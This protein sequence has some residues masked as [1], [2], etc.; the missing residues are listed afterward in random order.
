MS[1]WK[2]NLPLL[3]ENGI[4]FENVQIVQTASP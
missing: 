3:C 2:K 4:A 1:S